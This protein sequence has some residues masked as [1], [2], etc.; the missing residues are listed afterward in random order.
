MIDHLTLGKIKYNM[1]LEKIIQV[2]INSILSAEQFKTYL[3]CDSLQIML[4]FFF[5]FFNKNSYC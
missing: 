3:H 2:I 5:F 4:C 1:M